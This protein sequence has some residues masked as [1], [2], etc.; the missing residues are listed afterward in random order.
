MHFAEK[1]FSIF[2]FLPAGRQGQLS[3][4]KGFTLPELIVSVAI[5]AIL[6]TLVTLN[7]VG[8]KQRA[9]LDTTINVLLSDLKQQQLKAMTGD[10][11]GRVVADAYGMHTETNKY[12]LFHG[13]IFDPNSVDNFSIDLGDNVEFTTSSDIIFSRISGEISSGNMTLILQE[14]TTGVAR[15]INLNKYGIVTGVN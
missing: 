10:T 12:I 6:A 4:L 11:E 2:N 8:V 3:I 15:T 14:N 7:V 9:S 5:F 13:N 1:K